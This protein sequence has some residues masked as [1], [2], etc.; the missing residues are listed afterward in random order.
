MI[1]IDTARSPT[2]PVPGHR[3]A[4]P[5]VLRETASRWVTRTN[6]AH[7]PT[8]LAPASLAAI[9]IPARIASQKVTSIRT[10]R[11]RINLQRARMIMAVEMAV[12]VTTMA[13]TMVEGMTAMGTM[14][15]RVAETAARNTKTG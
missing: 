7:N 12:V 5:T 1:N 13:V 14:V 15:T 10:A 9:L 8:S 3:V 2:N 11:N 4:T 6:M